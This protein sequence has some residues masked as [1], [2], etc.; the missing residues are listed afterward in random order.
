[1]PDIDPA[2]VTALVGTDD[3]HGILDRYRMGTHQGVIYWT[4]PEDHGDE[5][6]TVHVIARDMAGDQ[7]NL[8][9]GE[10]VAAALEH[11]QEEHV[12]A[13]TDEEI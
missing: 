7:T 3:E 13:K 4:C 9:L 1:M 6:A 10:L 12:P 8:T 11:E 2:T 5:G